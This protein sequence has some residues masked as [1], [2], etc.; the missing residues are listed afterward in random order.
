MQILSR[1]IYLMH[2]TIWLNKLFVTL[3]DYNKPVWKVLL[4][5]YEEMVFKTKRLLA[6]LDN[7]CLVW[8]FQFRHLSRITPK[9]LEFW[10]SS[11]STL[12]M[13]R[14]IGMDFRCLGW[15]WMKLLSERFKTSLFS[16]KKSAGDDVWF[17]PCDNQRSGKIWL[18]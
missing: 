5:L 13:E 6:S 1:F 3:K 18:C 14:L 17:G 8:V 16:L 12:S 11:S 2:P 7:S 15:N 10:T 9:N 4:F